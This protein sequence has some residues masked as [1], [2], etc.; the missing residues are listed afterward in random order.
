MMSIVQVCIYDR[1]VQIKTQ[2]S[3]QTLQRNE[4]IHKHTCMTSRVPFQL[5][6]PTCDRPMPRQPCN[7]R[8]F[9]ANVVEN[10]LQMTK[11]NKAME[12]FMTK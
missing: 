6:N 11:A 4:P 2:Q 5:M 12:Q 3:K 7:I 10:K 9:V 1:S 8:F